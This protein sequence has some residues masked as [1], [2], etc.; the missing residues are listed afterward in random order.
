Y[1]LWMTAHDAYRV[2]KYWLQGNFSEEVWNRNDCPHC[3]IS[4]TMDHILTHCKTPGQKE[5][6]ELAKHMWTQKN[7]E[8]QQPWVGNITSCMITDFKANGEKQKH[9]E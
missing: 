6:W 7:L 2:G 8:W 4:K 3:N 1:F 5:I 9:L